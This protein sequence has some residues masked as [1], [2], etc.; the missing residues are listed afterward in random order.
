MGRTGSGM[1]RAFLAISLSD[2]MR[3]EVDSHWAPFRRKSLP[4]RWVPP[5]NLHVT[6]RFLGDL[7]DSLRAEVEEAAGEALSGA[8]PFSI[9]L[10]PT[11]AFPGIEKPR[12]LWVGLAEGGEEVSALAG[13]VDDAL[14]PLGFEPEKKFHPHITVGRVKAPLSPGICDRFS[15]VEIE[16]VAR[17]VSSAELKKS[18]LTTKGAIHETVR[19]L[20]LAG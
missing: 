5:E 16:P 8:A 12:V 2:E 6:L 1:I 18:I 10:G 14:R 9:A 15:G 17:T 20:D 7:N 4:V 11:G 3:L 13:L 19:I